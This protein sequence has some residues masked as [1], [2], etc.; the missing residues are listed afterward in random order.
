MKY[1]KKYNEK[2]YDEIDFDN[3]ALVDMNYTLAKD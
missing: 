1:L 3:K 2:I